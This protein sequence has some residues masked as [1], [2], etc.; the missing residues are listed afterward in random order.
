MSYY[1]DFDLDTLKLKYPAKFASEPEI[2]SRINRGD[3]IFIGTACGEPQYLVG[4]LIKYIDENPK[5]FFDAEVFHVWTLG[6]APYT[7]EK[8]KRNFRHNSFFIGETTREKVNRCMADYSPVFLSRTPDM[9]RSGLIPIDVALI[10]TSPPDEQGRMSL[11]ISV[12]IGMA[13]VERARLVIAQI[14][15]RMPRVPG[16]SFVNIS[17]IDYL[18]AFEEPL[19]EF[20][21]QVSD[22]IANRIGDYVARIVQDGDTIQV[23]YGGIPNAILSNLS[24]KRGLGAHT[25]LLTDGLVELMKSGAVDN[26]RKNLH[27]GATIA[28]FCMGTTPTYDFLHDNGNIEFRPIDYVN[29][30][31][32]IARNDNMTAINS[33]LEIDLTG[34]AT[35]DSIGK[36][37]YSGIGGSA[38][39]MR[40]AALSR[41]G[42]T[43]LVIQSTARD[44][45]SSRV[46]P[47]L[48]HG[49]G[50][51]ICRGDIHY[52]VTEHGIAS[53]LG[54][55]IRERAMSLI[56][57]AHPDFREWLVEEAKKE[58]LIYRD[59]MF[60]PGKPG[61]YPEELETYKTT[62]SGLEI[63]LRPVRISDEPALKDFFYSLSDKSMERR[64][65]S[66]RKDMPH[67]R[68]QEFIAIDYTKQMIIL[69]EI[70]EDGLD[71]IVGIG[72]YFICR[73]SHTGDVAF[74]VRDDWHNKGVGTELLN[75]LNLLAVRHGLLGLSG[76][77]LS[78]NEPMLH[79]FEKN[80]F[81]I[82]ESDIFGS[83]ALEKIFNKTT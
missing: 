40:G 28:S 82:V 61:E 76:E 51:T 75:Y 54:K 4:A 67:E 15:P 1:P 56:S 26:S 9:F 66:A 49:A 53:L 35:G 38:D 50:V 39:F 52:V 27:R 78:E 74:A 57:I 58:N 68:L 20:R 47:F 24:G 81:E 12:D 2:F 70:R 3:R 62:E 65:M 80:G 30:P 23:G 43:I 83:V 79:V 8:F 19:I 45:S 22:D 34:Q 69:A 73:N 18:V 17:D 14:N 29:N 44:G 13:A 21:R 36:Y 71:K 72:Q 46:K 11:G 55:N 60:V 42:K 59:Q 16:N 25:E 64:F 63:L 31:L 37:F 41:G 6:V 5:A 77:T 10:Q 33:A 48:S 32:V 7:D